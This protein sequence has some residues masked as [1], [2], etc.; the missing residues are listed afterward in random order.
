[1][2]QT[3]TVSF[4]QFFKQHAAQDT[5]PFLSVASGHLVAKP[6]EDE[7]AT[8]TMECLPKDEVSTSCDPSPAHHL[9]ARRKEES[10]SPPRL[11]VR[12]HMV[13][14]TWHLL[15]IPAGCLQGPR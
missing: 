4:R 9:C 6:E 15:H 7:H 5:A 12:S 10:P 3:E 8:W 11:D 1:M 13:S 2:T 14:N